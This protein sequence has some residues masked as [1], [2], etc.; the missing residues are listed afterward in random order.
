MPAENIQSHRNF[1][2]PVCSSSS[3]ILPGLYDPASTDI[4]P[5]ICPKNIIK[6]LQ[7]QVNQSNMP[8]VR[9]LFAA[10]FFVYSS[11]IYQRPPVVDW[12]EK[13]T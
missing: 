4:A 6:Q 11:A 9:I 13:A 8:S 7:D 2:L 10:V 1:C 5:L 3:D 12:F